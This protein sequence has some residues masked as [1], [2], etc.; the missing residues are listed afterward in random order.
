MKAIK[1]IKGKK[2]LVFEELGLSQWLYTVLKDAVDKL[3]VCS[4]SHLPKK[5]GPKNDFSDALEMADCRKIV[6]TTLAVLK[7]KKKYSD[8]K[9]RKEIEENKK[10]ALRHS[11]N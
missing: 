7:S 2:E 3:V 8:V 9:L 4:P 6:A 1:S 10:R 11:S 5:I